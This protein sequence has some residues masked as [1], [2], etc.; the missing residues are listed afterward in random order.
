[1]FGQHLCLC[2][3]LIV[4][5][6]LSVDELE[7]WASFSLIWN[8][9]IPIQLFM[10]W[11]SPLLLTVFLC[12]LSAF[13]GGLIGSTDLLLRI[14]CVG[15]S[16]WSR[17][18]LFS[19]QRRDVLVKLR[20]SSHVSFEWGLGDCCLSCGAHLHLVLL[21]LIWAHKSRPYVW[22]SPGFLVDSLRAD[23]IQSFA[24]RFLGWLV[25]LLFAFLDEIS[26]S[27]KF[28][29]ESKGV[30]HGLIKVTVVAPLRFRVGVSWDS[31][32]RAWLVCLSF[33][34]HLQNKF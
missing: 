1:M 18:F 14:R 20:A 13:I 25:H 15:F 6:I 24:D 33:F 17:H 4:E 8:I 34:K 16:V 9:F 21:L 30:S 26:S 27:S 22:L 5:P 2:D 28:M 23:T 19:A 29:L 11:R 31:L 10:N 7:V 12:M 3:W 32:L